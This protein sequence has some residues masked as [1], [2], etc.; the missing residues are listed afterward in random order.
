[1][2][3]EAPRKSGSRGASQNGSR[4][5]SS[6]SAQASS[7]GRCLY[8]PEDIKDAFSRLDGD[9]DGFLGYDEL[10]VILLKGSATALTEKQLRVLFRCVDKDRDNRVE[11]DEF[12]DFI[13]EGVTKSHK[14]KWEDT[15][16]AFAGRDDL[17]SR[18]EY[19]LLLETCGLYGDSFGPDEAEAVFAKVCKPS[20]EELGPKGF[21]KAIARIAKCK[22]VKKAVVLK[23]ITECAGPQRHADY[24][25]VPGSGDGVA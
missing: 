12:V 9:K 10:R 8:T 11:F 21:S 19:R 5:S 18:D 6:G 1:M 3:G 14:E 22:G 7:Q 4:G 25:L 15:F 23:A 17:L 24:G 16:L 20:E 13:Y 2:P